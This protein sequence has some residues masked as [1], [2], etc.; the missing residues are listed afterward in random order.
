MLIILLCLTNLSPT[1]SNIFGAQIF[2]LPYQTGDFSSPICLCV[3]PPPSVSIH[4]IKFRENSPTQDVQ[5][6]NKRRRQSRH[7]KGKKGEGTARQF[8][9]TTRAAR[10]RRQ[11]CVRISPPNSDMH[12]GEQRHRRRK[13]EW[14]GAAAVA[15]RRKREWRG[16]AAV[17]GRAEQRSGWCV[18]EQQHWL[19]CWRRRSGG[20]WCIV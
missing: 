12:L 20:S 3:N 8:R 16:A 1:Q 19:T 2:L 11:C 5:F 7:N 4:K 9:H 18:Y 14:R 6:T 17:A 13:R 15:G 10:Q